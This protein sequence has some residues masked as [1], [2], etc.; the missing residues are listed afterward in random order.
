MM[1]F[2]QYHVLCGG[3]ISVFLHVIDSYNDTEHLHNV[4]LYFDSTI[5]DYVY[6]WNI[7]AANYTDT[8]SCCY[9]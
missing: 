7:K 2:V 5:K 1:D 9:D 4:L 8:E 6:T 3:Y